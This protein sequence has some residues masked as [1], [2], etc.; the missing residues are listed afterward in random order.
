MFGRADHWLVRQSKMLL[1][2]VVLRPPLMTSRPS[3]S[4]DV[5]PQNMSCRVLL[6]SVNTPV[7]GFHTAA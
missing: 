2:R 6:I 5:P 7:A 4:M 3:G 1:S